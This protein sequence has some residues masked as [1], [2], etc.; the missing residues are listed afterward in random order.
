MRI[1]YNH[2]ETLRSLV[3]HDPVLTDLNYRL[4][5][6]VY[7]LGCALFR[8]SAAS[9][10]GILQQGST[11]EQ[12]QNWI[13]ECTD[14]LESR[15]RSFGL[16]PWQDRSIINDAFQVGC[17]I[18]MRRWC[19]PCHEYL[20]HWSRI[21]YTFTYAP[22]VRSDGKNA[23]SVFTVDRLK[24]F[25]SS[26]PM[27]RGDDGH[28]LNM[29]AGLESNRRNIGPLVKNFKHYFPVAV[30]NGIATAAK[31][32]VES[33]AKI[34]ELDREV[35]SIVNSPDWREIDTSEEIFRSATQLV[36]TLGQYVRNARDSR[37]L[38]DHAVLPQCSPSDPKNL[39]FLLGRIA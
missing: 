21:L 7:Q 1:T 22:Y 2:M 38:A 17:M 3:L 33:I 4:E 35:E 11:A 13:R 16:R 39:Q 18:P 28:L 25:A 34:N 30:G 36:V 15:S 32:H 29:F 9:A 31:F 20:S 6:A 23:L 26:Y 19:H 24:D 5:S 27:L 37:E 8:S 10:Q 12:I 14:R